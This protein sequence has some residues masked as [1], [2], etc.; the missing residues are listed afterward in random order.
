MVLFGAL[1]GDIVGSRF[2]F[3]NIKTKDFELFTD[4]CDFTDDSV[5]TIAVADAIVKSKKKGT[6]LYDETIKSLVEFC[7]KYTGRGYGDMFVHW[8]SPDNPHLPYNSNSN[9]AAMRV[10]PA[11]WAAQTLEEV[12]QLVYDVTA[13]SHNHPDALHGAEAVAVAIFLAKTGKTMEEIKSY[14]KEKYYDINFTV[15]GM[16]LNYEYDVTCKG[17][18]PQALQCFFEST[19]FEDAIRNAISIG[20]DSDTLGA[21]TGAIAEAFYGIPENIIEKSKEYLYWDQ[22]NVMAEFDSM[23]GKKE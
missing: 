6:S 10:S 14:I 8:I 4:K 22:Y 7:N 13:V 21:I 20:G 2:E 1:I 5:E 12:P 17:T 18:V 23:F 19:D 16:R 3:H 9:G 15:A 11:G